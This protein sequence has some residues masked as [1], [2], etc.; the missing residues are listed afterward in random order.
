MSSARWAKG[1][2]VRKGDGA[3][4]ENFTT[5]AEV[6]DVVGPN[7]S[8]TKID[9]TNQD[10]TS[11]TREKILGLRDP[12]EVGLTCN[13]LDNATHDEVTGVVKA[14]EDGTIGN[15]KFVWPFAAPITYTVPCGVSDCGPQANM[16]EQLKLG[17]TLM[18]AGDGTWS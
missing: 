7:S 14:H 1:V 17:F 3:S 9:V 2:L 16:D 18:L 8:R 11:G 15:W 5:I 6:H 13:W 10:S 12:G 4:P